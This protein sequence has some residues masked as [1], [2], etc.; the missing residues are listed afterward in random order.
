MYGCKNSYRI[1]L[2]L[3]GADCLL[4]IVEST[5]LRVFV[6]GY[7][8]GMLILSRC[9]VLQ[10]RENVAASRISLWQMIFKKFELARLLYFF[11][12]L[13]YTFFSRIILNRNAD[14]KGVI[15]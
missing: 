12:K 6:F 1:I 5:R 2:F 14:S 10:V 11:G 13:T 4:I 3:I 15:L 7:V 9:N 8:V